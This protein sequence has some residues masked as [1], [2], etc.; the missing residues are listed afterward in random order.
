MRFW[1]VRV[2]TIL[3]PVLTSMLY[4]LVFTHALRSVAEP[5][6]GVAYQAFLVPGL[7]MMAV[8]QMPSPTLLPR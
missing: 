3:A 8:L 7:A 2:Q 4:L 6:P 5:Y 1:K